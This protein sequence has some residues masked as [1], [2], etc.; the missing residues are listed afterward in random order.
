MSSSTIEFTIK[1]TLELFTVVGLLVAAP[2]EE[3][4]RA[5]SGSFFFS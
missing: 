4:L 3:Y 2:Y 5:L 1:L